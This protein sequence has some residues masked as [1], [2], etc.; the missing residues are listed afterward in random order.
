[1]NSWRMSYR[2]KRRM[3]GGAKSSSPSNDDRIVIV[4]LIATSIYIKY[5]NLWDHVWK[6][7]LAIV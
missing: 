6:A 5:Y 7:S 2:I 1:M 4:G 3:H